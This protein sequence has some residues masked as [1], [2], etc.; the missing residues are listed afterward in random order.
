MI[1]KKIACVILNYNDWQMTEKAA[2]M[3][4][5]MSAIDDVILVDNCS[6]D[7][8]F[9]QLASLQSGKVHVLRT[10]KNGGYGYG[11]NVGVNY[12]SRV[13]HAVYTLIINPDVEFG[14]KLVLALSGIMEAD[15]CAIASALQFF[16]SGKEGNSA[17]DIPSFAQTLKSGA[18]VISKL[19]R[20]KNIV[21]PVNSIQQVDCVAGSLLMVDTEVFLKI[22]G[23]DEGLFLYM[24]EIVLAERIRAYGYKTYLDTDHSYVHNHGATISKFHG[25]IKRRAMLLKSTEYYLRK[26]RCAKIPQIMLVRIVYTVGALELGA[27]A[28]CKSLIKR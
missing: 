10:K 8:S 23:Y 4:A 21:K 24:E 17:W 7:T 20:K 22:G 2:K 28:F 5:A 27:V 25:V 11:N 9:V 16:P 12:A 13:C 3:V 19:T 14:E 15:G 26:Y 18:P 6:T 1:N